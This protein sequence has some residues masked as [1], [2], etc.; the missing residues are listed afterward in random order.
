MSD[1]VFACSRSVY[2]TAFFID[3]TSELCDIVRV[4]VACAFVAPGAFS[5]FT[6]ERQ[7]DVI[8]DDDGGV[9]LA[10]CLLVSAQFL[11]L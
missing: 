6:A 5:L 4:L 1:T 8:R 3:R 7:A 10:S 2:E 11:F 9:D